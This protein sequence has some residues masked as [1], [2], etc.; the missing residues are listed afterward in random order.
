ML[1]LLVAVAALQY[2]AAI[3]PIQAG[4]LWLANDR[5]A[6]MSAPA[7]AGAELLVPLAR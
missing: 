6:T 5:P 2:L 1:E 3:K 7:E 4:A